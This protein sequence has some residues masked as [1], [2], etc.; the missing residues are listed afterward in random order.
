MS[1][2]ILGLLTTIRTSFWPS[3]TCTGLGG[4]TGMISKGPQTILSSEL[5]PSESTSPW[6]SINSRLPK[7]HS[8]GPLKPASIFHCRPCFGDKRGISHGVLVPTL[9]GCRCEPKLL[10]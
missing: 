4:T 10:G 7:Y 2:H 3:P 1:V 5:T 9:L 8:D 6:C